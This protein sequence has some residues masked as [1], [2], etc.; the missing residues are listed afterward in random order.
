MSARAKQM[1]VI[2]GMLSALVLLFAIAACSAQP[3]QIRDLKGIP[4]TDPDKARLVTNVD[5]YPNVVA[6][7][8]EGVGYITTTRNDRPIQ[9]SPGLTESWCRQ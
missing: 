1:R 6:I 7:C 9:E 4:V 3:Q 2:L 8:I 5:Q